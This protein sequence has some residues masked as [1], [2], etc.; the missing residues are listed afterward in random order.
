MNPNF[1]AVEVNSNEAGKL[2][3]TNNE[4]SYIP[5][6]AVV[7]LSYNGKSLLEKFLPPIIATKTSYSEIYVV[8]NA[9]TD[10]TYEFIQ[11][12][13]PQVKLI[14]LEINKG[15]TNGY[16]QSLPQIKAEYY[17][18]VS[19]DVEVSE[20]WIDPVIN[21]MDSDKSIGLVQPKI[22]SYNQKTHFEYSGAGG[23]Y[24]D[25]F[26]YPFCRGRMFF[27]IEEDKGQYDDI[28]ETFWCSGACMF[29]R[30]DVYHYLNGFDNDYYAHMEDIDLS[31]RAKNAG[32]K[33]MICPQSV[34]YHVGGH[35]I[36]YGSPPKIFRNYKNGLIMMVKNLPDGQIWWK[37]PFRILLDMV[38]GLRAL[39]TGNPKELQAIFKAHIE[40]VSGFR[41]WMKKRKL[42]KTQVK[43][44]N[45]KGVY[46]RSVVRQ[47]FLAAKRK[48]TDLDWKA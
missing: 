13:F 3:T 26:G 2:I 25:T 37:I 35:I 12:N 11:Q 4:Q 5:K 39:L 18:L 42:A 44:P 46:P 9:S 20:G 7:V 10:G 47:Y 8:D 30:A 38:A 17:A 27:T 29:I 40:F 31:W 34:V 28:V 36:S 32:Y 6:L 1:V 21:L 41:Q 43:N 22:K 23:A 48:F 14:R 33:V 24:I 16:V 45:L 19:S 15:F